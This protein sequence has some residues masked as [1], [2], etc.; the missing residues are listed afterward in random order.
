MAPS[1][2]VKS[3]TEDETVANLQKRLTFTFVSGGVE[4]V[5]LM[6]LSDGVWKFWRDTPGFSQRFTGTFSADGNTITCE[7]QMSR[8]GSNWEHDHDLTFT[9][10]L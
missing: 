9:K 1:Q 2:R 8:D 3:K 7:I 6:S 4:R 5:Y 10:E